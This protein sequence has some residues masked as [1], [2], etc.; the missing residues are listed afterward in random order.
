[1]NLYLRRSWS[2]G[3]RFAGDEK[4]VESIDSKVILMDERTLAEFMIDYEF[5]MT[6]T[7]ERIKPGGRLCTDEANALLSRI[8]K[9]IYLTQS[10]S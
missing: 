8:Q 5:D 4:Y 6:S 9:R 2:D 1:M 3:R 7:V 10:D